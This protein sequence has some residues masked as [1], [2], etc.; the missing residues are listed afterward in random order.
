MLS[1]KVDNCLSQPKSTTNYLIRFSEWSSRI[2][3]SRTR[4]IST[5]PS[6]I[7]L[8]SSL[9]V[10]WHAAGG[11]R[12]GSRASGEWAALC[13]LRKYKLPPTPHLLSDINLFFIA[14]GYFSHSVHADLWGK[15]GPLS[16]TEAQLEIPPCNPPF[17]LC[18]YGECFAHERKKN[19]YSTSW[20]TIPLVVRR[21]TIEQ[22]FY[23][24]VRKEP[25]PAKIDCTRVSID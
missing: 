17:Q 25:T 24:L 18:S 11:K 8:P 10:L 20:F 9:C 16:E 6:P 7:F 19:R 2:G 1:G 14:R 22:F 12:K 23:R 5:L 13:V 21:I 3:M 4:Y 15:R